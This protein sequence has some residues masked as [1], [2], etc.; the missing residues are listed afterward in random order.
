MKKYM[1]DYQAMLGA[2]PPQTGADFLRAILP[3]LTPH[4]IELISALLQQAPPAGAAPA[5]PGMD[6]AAQPAG[7][8]TGAPAAPA[9]MQ[10]ASAAPKPPSP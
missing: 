10:P 9:G 3:I 4:Q 7:M 1:A 5:A 8:K 2:Q 6:M